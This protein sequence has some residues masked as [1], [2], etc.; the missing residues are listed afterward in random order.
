[1]K[2]SLIFI[3]IISNLLAQEATKTSFINIGYDKIGQ[4][5][6]L[7]IGYKLAFCKFEEFESNFNTLST[8]INITSLN[9]KTYATP[10]LTYNFYGKFYYTG[11]SFSYFTADNK[12]DFRI[13]P[14]IGITYFNIF[15]VGY[16]YYIPLNLNNEIAD[17]G[18]HSFNLSISIP[19]YKKQKNLNDLYG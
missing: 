11:L 15:N 1:M 17:F 10:S 19:L 2:L 9:E 13:S 16:S 6:L 18:R 4:S 7:R 12:Q 14:Q 8:D 5:N 3:F